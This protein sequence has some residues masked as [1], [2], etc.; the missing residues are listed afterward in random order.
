MKRIS[1]HTRLLCLLL[2][3]PGLLLA[4]CGKK[5]DTQTESTKAE[6]AEAGLV[7][8]GQTV[9][10]A[11]SSLTAVLS[12]GEIEKLSQLPNLRFLDLRGS[13]NAA[14][15]AAWA[16]E[17]PEVDVSYSV[18]LPDGTTLDSDAYTADL[19]A[20]SADE[21]REAAGLL[22]LLPDL[23]SVDL[24][25]E[26]GGLKMDDVDAIRALLPGAELHYRFTLY[27]REFDLNDSSLNLR[28]IPVEDRGAAVRAV[29]PHMPQLRTV[30]MDSCG[31][32]NEDMEQLH[33]DFPDIKVIWRIWFAR[34]YSVRTDVERILASRPSVAGELWDD[35]AAQ[36]YYCHDVKYLDIGH[37]GGITSIGFVRGMP[38]LEVA[39]LAMGGWSDASPLA[40]CPNLEYLEMQST[41]CNDLS[42]LS[43]LTKLRHLNVAHNVYI[44]DITPLYGL[45]DLERFWLGC[46]AQV[47]REQVDEMRQ[48]CPKCTINTSVFEDPTTDHWRYDDCEFTDRYALLRVQF[49]GY[50][51]KAFSFAEN[52]PLY[53]PE[54]EG[55][56]PDGFGY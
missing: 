23:H 30:D 3:L 51:D 37:N 49:D 35:D 52:D 2:V 9:D 10:P 32:S 50:T 18:T 11:V 12:D 38:K 41:I 39:I 8:G 40:D 29:I 47:P 46:Y 33:L 16:A 27:G 26:K 22:A 55:V 28:Y 43:G 42:P 45:K 34:K 36:L 13:A 44:S 4:A 20:M 15:I 48:R 19:S 14:E 56:I 21:A 54:G 24:G 7:I 53:P 5:T 6:A 25:S 17:H 1:D 31:V